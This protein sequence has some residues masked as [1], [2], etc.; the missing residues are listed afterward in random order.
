[1]KVKRAKASI[2]FEN[3]P[4]PTDYLSPSPFVTPRHP[5]GG[6]SRGMTVSAINS[7]LNSPKDIPHNVQKRIGDFMANVNLTENQISRSR[8]KSLVTLKQM[9]GESHKEYDQ[10]AT[11]TILAADLPMKGESTDLQRQLH[12]RKALMSH[13]VGQIKSPREFL[14][15]Y[16]TKT[17]QLSGSPRPSTAGWTSR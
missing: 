6:I 7:A 12:F 10:L 13:L 9:E 4:E 17:H 5:S 14:E 3:L 2:G 8:R 15:S 1:M 16:H 11:V